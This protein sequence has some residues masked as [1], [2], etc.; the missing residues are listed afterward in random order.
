MQA[1]DAESLARKVI[2]LCADCD[3]CRDFMED[4]PCLFF[5]EL[6]RLHDDEKERG[7]A[8]ASGELKN[9]LD[10]CNMCGLCSC[11]SVRADIRRAKDAFI[12][13]DGL[14]LAIRLLEDVQL[15]GRLCGAYP[16]LANLLSRNVVTSRV[17]KT[18][19]GIHPDRKLPSFPPEGFDPWAE[20]RGLHRKRGGTGRKVAYFVGCTARYLFPQV[21]KAAVE[22]LER[23]GVEVY[24]PEQKCCGMPALLEGDKAFTFSAARFNLD[25]LAEVV[26]DGYDVVCS[27]PTCG[28]V[29]KNLFAEGAYYSEAYRAALKQDAETPPGAP[30]P[31]AACG[32]RKAG[33]ECG[34]AP[35]SQAVMFA[36][37]LKGEAKALLLAG[38]L[39]DESYFAQLDA[40]K[41]IA[42]SRQTFDLGEYLREMDRAGE[43]NRQLGPVPGRLAYFAP[44]HLKE[45]NVGQPWWDL[46]GLIPGLPRQQ[47]G[48]AF[49]CCGI[50]GIMGFKREFHETS[51]AMGKRL[52]EKI[53]AADPD[54][55]ACD[56]L[57]CRIQFDQMLPLE[58]CH[59]V[60]VLRQAYEAH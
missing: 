43:L 19:A 13:R 30:K 34:R 52:M 20:R 51:L 55:V 54:R 37:L 41:R 44:C 21:A 5:A 40:V 3:Q 59:P 2:E 12:A 36:N 9:L 4:T 27:C 26:E 57:S 53:Q 16:R 35:S 38:L 22:V 56:C 33:A 1:N 17:L 39:K 60:E 58:A 14:P 18:A 32:S 28:Y 7:R 24:L 48:G 8:P 42:V 15:V 46:L 50:A 31:A 45:Q 6:Y 29:L 25:R 49:D 23:N 47:V 10:L 11:P